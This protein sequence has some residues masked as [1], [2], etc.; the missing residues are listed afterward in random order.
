MKT[1][2]IIVVIAAIAL[3]TFLWM[4]PEETTSPVPKNITHRPFYEMVKKEG[5][6]EAEKYCE[7][8]HDG[9]RVTFPEDH[10]PKQRCLF[11]HK[12]EE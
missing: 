4:A 7:T 12:I 2:D 10:P 3:L 5:K 8:C 11:C 9:E 6:K 1:R